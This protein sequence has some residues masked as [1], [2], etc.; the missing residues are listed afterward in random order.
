MIE[1]VK[2]KR[3]EMGLSIDSYIFSIDDEPFRVYMP[4]NRAVGQYCTELGMPKRSHHAIRRT[5]ISI[6]L[7]NGLS[8][9]EVMDYV[10]HEHF[11]TTEKSYLMNLYKPDEKVSR[12]KLALAG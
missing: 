11:S 6:C 12:L 1:E 5:F 4:I 7:A 3:T 8:I 10:G 9:K 2:R